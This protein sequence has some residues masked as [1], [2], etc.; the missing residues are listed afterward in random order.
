MLIKIDSISI[1]VHYQMTFICIQTCKIVMAPLYLIS[2]SLL[3]RSLPRKVDFSVPS[4][5]RSSH[6]INY[7]KYPLFCGD[8]WHIYRHFNLGDSPISPAKSHVKKTIPKPFPRNYRS[9]ICFKILQSALFI[10]LWDLES[11]PYIHPNAKSLGTDLYSI[12]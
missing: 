2:K 8:G 10:F 7:T 5:V 12:I 6:I 3:W 11:Y 4:P 9:I 1:F